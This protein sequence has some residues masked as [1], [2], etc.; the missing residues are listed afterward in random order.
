M[1]LR[2]TRANRWRAGWLLAV[3]YWLCVLTPTISFA[4]PGQARAALCLTDNDR[5]L[6]IMHVHE[7]SLLVVQHAGGGGQAPEGAEAFAHSGQVRDH[8]QRKSAGESSLPTKDRHTAPHG[9]CCGM[10][11][12]SALP[13]AIVEIVKPSEPSA[14]CVSETCRNVADK[15]PPRLY[16]PPIS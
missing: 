14:F 15:S 16:R 6:G 9:Q 12:V 10:V 7:P 8:G 4:L 2:L 13:A 11:C 3:V 1:T 5:G